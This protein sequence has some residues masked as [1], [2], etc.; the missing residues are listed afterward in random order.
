MKI[1]GKNTLKKNFYLSEGE[2]PTAITLEGGG[3]KALMALPLK[4]KLFVCGFPYQCTIISGMVPLHCTG[5]I[6]V[7][8]YSKVHALC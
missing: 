8:L 4:K 7:L 1:N 5:G 3:V 2:I 6:E